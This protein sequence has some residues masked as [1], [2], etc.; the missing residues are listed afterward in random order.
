[1]E[2]KLVDII[3][4]E[5]EF[6]VENVSYEKLNA[7]SEK[8]LT[9]NTSDTTAAS[10]VGDSVLVR[11][12]REVFFSPRQLF[13]ITVAIGI[14]FH[15]KDGYTLPDDLDEKAFVGLLIEESPAI[16]NNAYSRISAIISSI[17]GF[18]GFQPLVTQPTLIKENS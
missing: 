9:L 16:I 7:S 13:S 15:L 17:T 10:F 1:M 8:E 18:A 4:D 11:L 3:K 14:V 6:S 2:I 12:E 5:Y